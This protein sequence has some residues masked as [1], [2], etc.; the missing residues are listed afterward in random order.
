[1]SRKKDRATL[2]KLAKVKVV[3]WEWSER[4]AE[5]G[6][7]PGDRA[8]GVIAQQLARHYPDLVRRYPDGYRRVDYGGLAAVVLAG[9]Q[10]LVREH[11]ALAHRVAALERTAAKRTSPPRRRR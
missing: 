1:V 2:E 3:S 8:I 5:V 11:D 4:A 10:E 7:E 9:L 6:I